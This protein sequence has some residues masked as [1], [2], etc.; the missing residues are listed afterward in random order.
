MSTVTPE[1]ARE[2]LEAV[3]TTARQ[4]QR[5]LANGGAAYYLFVWGTVWL[6]GFGSTYFLGATSPL[7]GI[8]WLV[9]DVLGVA[10]SFLIGWRMSQR[11]RSRVGV[12]VGLFWLAWLVY[13]ALIV[14]FAQPTTGNQLSLLLS[15]FAMMGYVT[16][17]L[18]FDSRFLVVVGLIVTVFIIAGYLFA[19]AIFN[20]W[21]AMLGGGSLLAAGAYIQRAWR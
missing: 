12:R 7:S 16:S 15:L 5:T 14:Q 21:M 13:A 19:P 18:L 2:A 4:V 11:V 8:I 3:R 20:L 17:G 1:E 9:L 6:L 10:A